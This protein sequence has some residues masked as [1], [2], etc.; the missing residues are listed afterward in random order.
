M[1][2]SET[3]VALETATPLSLD[4]LREGPGDDEAAYA[5]RIYTAFSIWELLNESF[6]DVSFFSICYSDI[7]NVTWIFIATRSDTC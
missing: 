3:V 6:S 2:I 1:G 4:W 7:F 5:R